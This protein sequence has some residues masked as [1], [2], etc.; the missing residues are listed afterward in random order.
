MGNNQRVIIYGVS[1][2]IFTPTH[3]HTHD[4]TQPSEARDALCTNQKKKN[5]ISGDEKKLYSDNT[6]NKE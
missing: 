3:T 4:P 1:V 6:K 5:E 2:S